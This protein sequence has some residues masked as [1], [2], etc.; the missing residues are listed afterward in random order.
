MNPEFAICVSAGLEEDLE[1]WK[2]YPLIPDP[3]AEEVK[4]LR[5][6]D[7]SGEEYL[8]PRERFMKIDLP[9]EIRDRLLEAPSQ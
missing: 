7:D 8:Y 2:V 9:R 4:C 3:A 1:I 5:V 6:I